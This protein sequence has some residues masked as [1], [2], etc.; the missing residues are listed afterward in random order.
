MKKAMIIIAASLCLVA[1]TKAK[2]TAPQSTQSTFTPTPAEN[3]L[4]GDWILDSTVHCLNYVAMGTNLPCN[5]SI[6]H[7]KLYSTQ[8]GTST[9]Q[10]GWMDA[11]DGVTPTNCTGNTS[12]WRISGTQF[13]LSNGY[14]VIVSSSLHSFIFQAVGGGNKY[15]LHK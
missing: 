11:S 12:L 2:V 5:A 3:S 14:Y 4:M 9:P 6:C 15:Y 13:Q 10:D 8:N 1:C 7:L